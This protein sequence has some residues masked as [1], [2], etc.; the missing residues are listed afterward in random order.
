MVI[1]CRRGV[2]GGRNPDDVI[3]VGVA[4]IKGQTQ[5]LQDLTSERHC[6]TGEV[7]SGRGVNGEM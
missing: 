6:A 7:W 1:M 2:V 3:A 4:C 5:C